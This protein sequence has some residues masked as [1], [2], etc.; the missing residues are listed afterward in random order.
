MRANCYLEKIL[1]CFESNQSV[2]QYGED[3]GWVG[4]NFYKIPT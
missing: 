3:L 1:E 2:E 4:V